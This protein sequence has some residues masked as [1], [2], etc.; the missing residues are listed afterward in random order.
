MPEL[1]VNL[2]EPGPRKGSPLKN[3]ERKLVESFCRWYY[4]PRRAKDFQSV[5]ERECL[6]NISAGL[7]SSRLAAECVREVV[8]N[9]NGSVLWVAHREY[10]KNKSTDSI[11]EHTGLTVAPSIHKHK[12][13]KIVVT[14]NK[15]NE[16]TLNKL[17]T[18][19][20]PKLIVIDEAQ[21]SFSETYRTLKRAFPLAKILNLS[22]TPFRTDVFETL[23]LGRTLDPPM[24]PSKA[25]KMGL[26]TPYRAVAKLT[27]DFAE[28]GL[29]QGDYRTKGLSDIMR[30]PEMLRVSAQAIL[31]HAPGRRGIIFCCSNEHTE[32]LDKHLR[33]GGLRTRTIIQSTPLQKRQKIYQE[34]KEGQI[35]QIL[36]VYCLTEGKEMPEV[37]MISI[38]RPTKSASGY[39]HMLARGL[40]LSPETEKKDCLLIDALD[41][42]KVKGKGKKTRLPCDDEPF[43]DEL[44]RYRAE[45]G[46]P[47]SAAVLYLSWFKGNKELP[48]LDS[49]ENIYRA[50]NKNCPPDQPALTLLRKVW[51]AGTLPV[52][53]ISGFGTL[54]FGVGCNG[55]EHLQ[56]VLLDKGY[57]YWPHGIEDPEPGRPTRGKI[58]LYREVPSKGKAKADKDPLK[59]L[60][61]DLTKDPQSSKR[62][63]FYGLDGYI[64]RRQRDGQLPPPDSP[65]KG[66]AFWFKDPDTGL[67]Y[68]DI[69]SPQVAPN[70]PEVRTLLLLSP[71]GRAVHFDSKLL[72]TKALVANP[73]DLS[74]AL[75]PPSNHKTIR[76]AEGRQTSLG[77]LKYVHKSDLKQYLDPEDKISPTAYP[78]HYQQT[79][80]ENRASPKQIG[81]LSTL[82]RSRQSKIPHPLDCLSTGEASF[83]ITQ[84]SNDTKALLNHL[85]ARML[86][87]D[88]YLDV[89][90]LN[91]KLR[92]LPE[93]PATTNS[94][95][96][97]IAR[98]VWKSKKTAVSPAEAPDKEKSKPQQL[99]PPPGTIMVS[100]Q[101]Y[102]LSYSPE[103]GFDYKSR[104][105]HSF[106]LQSSAYT[107][108]RKL[109]TSLTDRQSGQ[110]LSNLDKSLGELE[111]VD[112]DPETMQ[113]LIKFNE[114]LAKIEK[115]LTT[116]EQKLA[117]QLRAVETANS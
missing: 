64:V 116:E 27:H 115:L 112:S 78:M 111:R 74:K 38:L 110:N 20:D 75:A 90:E 59:N 12:N 52:D 33:K 45:I 99:N 23:E 48:P 32:D 109:L 84:Y 101:I 19:I 53:D 77:N 18:Q 68:M 108:A 50:V 43:E 87:A 103:Y 100:G 67:E 98:E 83:L 28:A 76:T 72:Y 117:V 15:I 1:E 17:Q 39:V 30:T 61:L 40:R 104:L 89:L 46:Q 95:P 9:D 57:S 60:V 14:G 11:R 10:L 41:V 24:S 94:S 71:R 56:K 16:I 55:I 70:Q 65:N 36:N 3:F 8:E 25:V 47:V 35:D 105:G 102:Y 79:S 29:E 66:D 114:Q 13:E 85:G 51:K 62:T 49:P 4:E 80:W 86:L 92:N 6:I 97:E 37:D 2:E 5:N 113:A 106:S 81:R 96:L 91:E 42:A 44:V 54:A 93:K 73:T 107:P 63:P 7:D 22:P 21:R 58:R 82:I 26:L 88:A 69:P 31:E 34:L